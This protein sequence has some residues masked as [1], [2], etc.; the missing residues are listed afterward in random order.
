MIFGR[1]SWIFIWKNGG[2]EVARYISYEAG[3]H[4]L[5]KVE[6]LRGIVTDAWEEP[7]EGEGNKLE[8]SIK[9]EKHMSTWQER[10]K[11]LRHGRI[12][13]IP[14]GY[15]T[16]EMPK[17]Y[18]SYLPI[19][20]IE[21][22]SHFRLGFHIRIKLASVSNLALLARPPSLAVRCIPSVVRDTLLSALT[23]L[24]KVLYRI[25]APSNKT[26]AKTFNSENMHHSLP[27]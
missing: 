24:G 7:K 9:R 19:R 22:K 4:H 3:H 25:P 17:A 23:S 10:A 14:H 20:T 26:M 15:S 6:S 21:Y 1:K 18:L 11:P 13:V 12:F 27:I 2:K 16:Q 8:K 5:S